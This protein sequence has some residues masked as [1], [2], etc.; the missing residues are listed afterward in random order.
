MANRY[1]A[2]RY[3]G[4]CLLSAYFA[5]MLVGMAVYRGSEIFPFFNWSLF[6]Y[7]SNER[8]V[9]VVGFNKIN[10][11]ALPASLYYEL[12]DTFSFARAKD[13]AVDKTIARLGRAI[14]DNDAATIAA[15]R[16]LLEDRYMAEVKSAEYSVIE[17]THDPIK[18]LRTGEVKQS[19]VLGTFK[20]GVQ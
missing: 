19:V 9:V 1:Y 13:I 5:V 3:L 20:K 16:K 8:T 11:T 17:Q 10:D 14:H 12:T 18:R 15:M 7:S 2:Y 6:S 4:P